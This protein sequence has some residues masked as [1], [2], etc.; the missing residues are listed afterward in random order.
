MINNSLLTDKQRQES[1]KEIISF[2]DTERGEE[3]G[4]IAAENILE[5]FLK[6]TGITLYN[7]GV[8][9]TKNYLRNSLAEVESGIDIALKKVK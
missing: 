3:I 8:E 7:K 6:T 9:D 5:M 2:F 1:I 4:Y